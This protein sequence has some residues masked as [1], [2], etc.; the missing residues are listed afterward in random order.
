[1]DVERTLG[2]P[3][4][5]RRK[6]KAPVEDEI[7]TRSVLFVAYTPGGAL[8]KR[9]REVVGRLQG[10]LGGGI[11][12]VER[13]GTPL[14]RMFPL[15]RLWEGVACTRTDCITRRQGGETIYPCNKRNVV[16]EDVCLLCYPEAAGK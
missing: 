16:Y 1:M 13:T 15:S 12:I 7:R 4:Q 10:L 8:A 5:E 3:G 2:S 9:L 14:A 6:E 11:K